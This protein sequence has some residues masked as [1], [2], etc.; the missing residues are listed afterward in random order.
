MFERTLNPGGLKLTLALAAALVLSGCI[1]A[2]TRPDADA[3]AAAAAAEAEA[4]RLAQGR[5]SHWVVDRGDNLWYIAGVSDVYGQSEQWPLLY[6]ANANQIEDADL[7]YPGQVLNVPRDS[8]AIEV[9]RAIRHARN[10]G[11][12]AV[13]P[14]E[15][16]DQ[17]YLRGN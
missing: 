6:K 17:A 4:A 13:G 7:I 11:A 16:S 1:S 14:I 10:R 12:W 2:K 9:R 5:L 15:P 8:S 3:Q